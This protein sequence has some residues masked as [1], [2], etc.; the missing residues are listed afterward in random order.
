MIDKYAP[1][2]F[3]TT[4]YDLPWLTQCLKGMCKKKQ[5]LYNK[6]K[7]TA[8]KKNWEVFH[9][10]KRET[11]KAIHAAHCEYVNNILTEPGEA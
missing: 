4:R 3:T 8:K 11:Q 6:A 10:F 2:K 5:R 7:R 9:A 1:S